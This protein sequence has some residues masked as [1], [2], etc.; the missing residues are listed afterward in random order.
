MG[1]RKLKTYRFL[2]ERKRLT[3]AAIAACSA[4]ILAGL[5]LQW[6]LACQ[7]RVISI[8]VPQSIPLDDAGIPMYA[9]MMY[10]DSP[11]LM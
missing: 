7:S 2:K 6:T 11:E 9:M 3:C 10:V 8:R 5:W 1:T 4:V